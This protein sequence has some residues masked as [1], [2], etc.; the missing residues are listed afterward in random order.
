MT[1][2]RLFA[3][4]LACVVTL[5]NEG[6]AQEARVLSL[7]DAVRLAATQSGT[8]LAARARTD[9]ANARTRE[10][11]A[12]LLP[13]IGATWSDGQRSFNTASF[14]I[15]F[16]GFDPNGSIIGPVRTIDFRAHVQADLY[17][18]GALSDYRNTQA[19]AA[20]TEA[21]AAV[22]AEA[23]MAMAAAAY[24]RLAHA[25]ALVSARAADSALASELVAIAQEELRAGVGVAL[26]VS[27][28]QTQ[29]ASVRAQLI[30]A[31]ND[32]DRAQLELLRA[33]GL[34]LTTNLTLRDTLGAGTPGQPSESAESAVEEALRSRADVRALNTAIEASTR[35]VR[36]VHSERLPTIALFAD[37]GATSAKYQYLKN[38]YNYGVQVSV[39]LFEGRRDRAR[40][41]ERE[42]ILRGAEQRRRDLEA[43]INL[44]VRAALL[45]LNSAREQVAV[46]REALGFAELALN[47]ARDRFRTG[48]AGSSDVV[49]AQLD[50]GTSRRQLVDALATLEAA[51]ISLARAQGGLA[52]LQ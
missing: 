29:L 50:L 34:P 15:P 24:V 41:E 43:Q 20:R 38:T 28:S 36:A 2:T 5:A 22:G 31:R 49:S 33:V 8:V 39:P 32:R 44:D 14:G 4:L 45:D 12:N 42:A 25:G 47:Q 23:A 10:S 6:R 1:H 26:D 40:A 16:P 11:H 51:R 3:S 17:D 52:S 30:V 35:A 21:D 9:E 37:E 18:P 27:R 48:V 46:A 7:G 19:A 13:R